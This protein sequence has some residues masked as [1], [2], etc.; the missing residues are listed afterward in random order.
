MGYFLASGQADEF[1]GRVLSVA[2]DMDTLVAR[3]DEIRR[4]GQYAL[5][6]IE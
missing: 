2:H 5:R 1:S 3:S 6:L 4:E